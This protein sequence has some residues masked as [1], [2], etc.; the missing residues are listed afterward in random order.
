MR[1]N[2][3]QERRTKPRVHLCHFPFRSYLEM[4][5]AERARAS[6]AFTALYYMEHHV[7]LTRCL[8]AQSRLS[9]IPFCLNMAASW[10]VDACGLFAMI[11]NARCV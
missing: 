10:R 6:D 2:G 3:L 7:S 1:N 8:R 4:G 11:F 9:F 5:K